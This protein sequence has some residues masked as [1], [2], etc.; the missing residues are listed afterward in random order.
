MDW[1][2]IN[3]KQPDDRDNVL[4]YT[5]YEFFGET[6]SCVGNIESIRSCRTKIGSRIVPIFTHWMPL[7]SKPDHK[8]LRKCEL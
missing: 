1:V 2:N 7:P 5:P 3:E 6:H 4:L 8:D